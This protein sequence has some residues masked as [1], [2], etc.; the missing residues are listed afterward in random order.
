MGKKSCRRKA[1]T[2]KKHSKRSCKKEVTTGRKQQMHSK[3]E[4]LTT[5][6]LGFWVRFFCKRLKSPIDINIGKQVSKSGSKIF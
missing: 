5:V 3:K 1:T 6:N 4:D 2:G